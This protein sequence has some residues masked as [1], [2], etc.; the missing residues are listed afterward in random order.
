MERKV[1]TVEFIHTGPY[2]SLKSNNTPNEIPEDFSPESFINNKFYR[3][4]KKLIN[5]TRNFTPSYMIDEV[6]TKVQK[7]EYKIVF[8]DYDNTFQIY[9]GAFPFQ[10]ST[11]L[12]RFSK[13]V[14]TII[15]E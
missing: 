9:N 10:N 3:L 2:R 7:G 8:T 13:N 4:Y 6:K 14:C 1:L 12:D 15:I 11:W 5:S